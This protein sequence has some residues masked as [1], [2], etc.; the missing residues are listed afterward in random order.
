MSETRC[1]DCG[2]HRRIG[3]Y[4]PG[5]DA[6]CGSCYRAYKPKIRCEG[7]GRMEPPAVRAG[8]RSGSPRTLCRRCYRSERPQRRCDGCGRMRVINSGRS[9]SGEPALC[10][11]CY[12]KAR[13]ETVCPQC[14]QCFQGS[15]SKLC[16]DCYEHPRRVCGICGRERRVAVK[17]S[18]SGPDICPTCHQAPEVD[19][20]I[21]SQ[22]LRGRLTGNDGRPACFGCMLAARVQ[23]L[24]TGPEGTI[25]PELLG[26]RE[27]LVDT[28]NPQAALSNFG[29]SP[30]HK[31]LKGIASGELP[32]AHA[33]LDGQE[34]GYSIRCLRDLLVA[35]GALQARDEPMA[36]LEAFAKAT[37][38]NAHPG[39][40]NVLSLFART[41]RL[42]RLRRR[43][44]GGEIPP[45]VV[46]NA[47]GELGTA[48]R[49]LS[50]LRSRGRDRSTCNQADVDTWLSISSTN[51]QHTTGFL[52]WAIKHRHMP[53]LVVPL[54]MRS[55]PNRFAPEDQRWTLAKR[56]HTDT[57]LDLVDRVVGSLVLLYAQ[58]VSRIAALTCDQ[59]VLGD[60][61]VGLRLGHTDLDLIEPLARLVTRLPALRDGLPASPAGQSPWLFPGR[62]PG[63]PLHPATLS[64]R[65]NALGIDPRVTRNGALMSYAREL[66]PPVLGRLLGFSPGTAEQWAQIAGGKW[67][68][69]RPPTR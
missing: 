14:G 65:L 26:V 19:C 7:C 39:D 18:D 6:V 48:A 13:P 4:R 36:R 11:T 21:C 10:V 44:D 64:R 17:A 27:A 45:N 40:R 69:Y 33:T 56:L 67:A 52:N 42:R 66:P 61:K 51:A 47:R 30:A 23:A 16:P 2:R 63:R 49:F 41:H 12:V 55:F 24:L 53:D 62:L 37:A 3:G 32:L 8:G 54:P 1:S 28:A 58:P 38:E 34:Q 50:W 31:L 25:A 59:V 43:Y 57:G 9:G 5:G 22:R 15:G 68:R 60:G 29:R 46:Y 20:S 35:T